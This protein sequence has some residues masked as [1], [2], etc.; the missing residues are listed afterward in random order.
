LHYHFPWLVAAN[1]R[2]SV[3]CAA[4]KRPMRLGLD[5]TPYFEVADSD[6]PYREKLAAYAAIARER[7]QAD[8][9]EDFCATHLPHLD[10]V[11]WDFFASDVAHDAVRQKVA[12][13]FPLHEIEEF[14]ALFWERIQRWRADS[15][16]AGAAAG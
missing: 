15:V 16:P 8:E 12:A 5:W 1:L 7:F 6:A 10:Q 11:V 13:L 3:F 4:T 14:T 9:F 2:W